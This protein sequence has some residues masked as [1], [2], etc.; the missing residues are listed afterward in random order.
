VASKGSLWL[1]WSGAIISIIVVATQSAAP[2][3]LALS[4]VVACATVAIV[5]S[6]MFQV[7]RKR[8]KRWETGNYD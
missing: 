6:A 1:L 7:E 3:W 5:A 2:T 4:W 8:R